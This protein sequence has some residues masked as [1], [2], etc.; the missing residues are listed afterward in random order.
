MSFFSTFIR[1]PVL[2]VMINLSL[3]VIGLFCY[4]NLG[5]DAYPQIQFPIVTIATSLDGAGTEEIESE[6]TK[7]IEDQVA[8]IGGI[9]F[10]S[11]TTQEGLS[12][13]T[14][15][16]VL[17]KDI[18]VAVQEVRDKVSLIRNSFPTGT[19]DPIIQK[20]D[21]N[22][23][24]VIM[25]AVYGER[26]PKEI[27]E[28]CRQQVK[29]YIQSVEGV[30]QVNMMGAQ[31]REVEVIIDANK[32]NSYKIPIAKVEQAIIDQNTEIPGGRITSRLNE[33]TLRTSGRLTNIDSFNEIIIDQIK[34]TPVKLKDIGY[35]IDG[36]KEL[37]TLSRLNGKSTIT[38]QVIKNTD[39]N[40]VDVCRR[41]KARV[42][43]L[44][45][46][47]PSDI[48]VEVVQDQSI[49][50]EKDVHDIMIHLFLGGGLACLM[51]FLFMKSLR[52]T[53][54]AAIAIPIS[55]IATF[56]IMKACKFTLNNVTLLALALV[57]GIVID[58]AIVVLE[59]IWRFIEEEG[60]PPLEAAI[61]GIE[62]V[63]FAVLATTLSLIVLFL[64]IAFMPGLVGRYFQS[65]GITM[66]FAI[67]FSMVV[68]FTLT[69]ML[70]S[71]LLKTPKKKGKPDKLT[72]LLQDMYEALL[73]FCLKFRWL[74]LLIVFVT[75]W[76]GFGLI[77]KVGSEFITNEDTGDYNISVKL[78]KG[79]PMERTSRALKPI[80]EEL[81][82]LKDIKYVVTTIG[83]ST[84]G[85][86]DNEGSNIAQA[87]IY[88]RMIE[89]DKRKN[90][91]V[92]QSMKEARKIL[93]KYKLFRTAVQMAQG[94]GS[95]SDDDFT[96]SIQGPDLDVLYKSSQELLKRFSK[97]TGF[98]DLDTDLDMAS[99]EVKV[100]IDRDIATDI[101]INIKSASS[102]LRTMVGGEKISS[103]QE[104]KWMYDVR[105]RLDEKD[106][107][108]PEAIKKLYIASD[109]GKKLIYLSG[110]ADITKGFGP[111]TIK[112]YN[113]QRMVTVMANL[114]DYPLV[115]A[116]NQAE[117]YVKELNLPSTYSIAY[118][119][120]SKYVGET[121]QAFAIA[122]L[123]AV[124]FMYMVLA[125]QFEN[126]LDPL[127]IL[128]TLPLSIPFALFALFITHKTLNMFSALG[129]FLLFGI[130][131]KNAILQIDHYNKLCR[132]GV[133]H[134]EAILR[135]N[136]ERLRPI[137]MTTATLVIGM[138]PVAVAGP[139]GAARSP[140]AVVVVGGQSLCLILTL[141]LIPV[142]QS[143]IEDCRNFRKWR[144]F[145]RLFRKNDT[146]KDIT[147]KSKYIL[148]IS[149]LDKK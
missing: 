136:R 113:R 126:Y 51:V 9:Y 149:D 115:K 104:G 82:K 57:V 140:M 33:Y 65:Y 49:Y 50:I 124:I 70:C 8:V 5:V 16:F 18:N 32:L 60:K 75:L 54:I 45:G 80:E 77:Q 4:V 34:N 133:P 90:N 28:L 72:L 109:D 108:T 6:I 91:T 135:A 62:D 14:V 116:M 20:I 106:R 46:L 129:L 29:D 144:I 15:Q 128:L 76:W 41:I 94:V 148:D 130:V 11:S 119:G 99:P 56:S 17:E 132:E 92:F 37:R 21:A 7:R 35:V 67:F 61:A 39:A 52:S 123:L 24:P 19:K 59:N 68:S 102:A 73:K 145:K 55:I 110:I 146:G 30:G 138:M 2:S 139:D 36:E 13:V 141:V 86:D 142:V 27:T 84:G 74:V 114:E 111:S 97:I 98:V 44:K 66:A 137:L 12:S 83:T 40:T 43:E 1:H 22:S 3:V 42:E 23:I 127:I 85:S 69:P 89:Y 47:L 58:D 134:Y 143:Y 120:S 95:S 112:H 96:F 101:G 121:F 63:G 100:K 122:F 26:D 118:Q 10:V 64:P 31:Y 81:L 87:N 105:I 53:F 131:K 48:H 147:D 103:F 78:P 25:L 38:L 79:W 93:R 71:K 117:K 88:V 125:S 107:N